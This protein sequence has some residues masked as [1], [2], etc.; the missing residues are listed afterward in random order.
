M[1][2]TAIVCMSDKGAKGER[3]DLSTSV[4]EKILIENNYEVVKKY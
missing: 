4:I 2:R 3:E 1:F